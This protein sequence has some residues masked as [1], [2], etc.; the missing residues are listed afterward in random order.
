VNGAPTVHRGDLGDASERLRRLQRLTAAASR[1]VT[2]EDV[3]RDVVEAA[4]TEV[5][6]DAGSLYVLDGDRMRHA[7]SR[8]LLAENV[9]RWQ[10]FD[11]DADTPAGEA[12]R[13]RRTVTWSTRAERDERWSGLRGT[14]SA[15][16]AWVVAP[17]VLERG[18]AGFLVLGFRDSRTFSDDELAFVE[19]AADVSAQAL[20]RARLYDAQREAYARQQ[21]LADAGPVLASSLD[22]RETIIRVARLAV[23]RIADGCAVALFDGDDLVPVVAAH[24]DEERQE[25]FDRLTARQQPVRNERVLA[26]AHGGEPLVA[27]GVTADERAASAEDP[28]HL[29]LIQAF[30]ATAAIM[31]ALPG[32]AANLGVLMLLS[33]DEDRQISAGDLP[34]IEDLAARAALAI[35]NARAHE[36]RA[37]LAEQL[38][39]A[40]DSRVVIEQ[41]KGILAERHEVDVE[42]AFRLLRDQAR[43]TNRKLHDVAA[44]VIDGSERIER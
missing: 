19:A 35:E 32:R 33:T 27:L 2:A 8:G 3:A 22:L 13:G 15:H 11:V 9:Q 25:V 16:D 38:Q 29:A 40:L 28:E 14:P 23:P 36:D 10:S 20:E 4:M 5:G 17:P 44:A 43:R 39:G 42:T 12:A 21:F 37:R 26:V 41:A 30:G 24:H 6:A 18:A 1:A 7:Y 31:V 34:F